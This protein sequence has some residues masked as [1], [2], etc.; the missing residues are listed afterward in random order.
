MGYAHEVRRSEG[1]EGNTPVKA[2]E[3][4]TIYRHQGY[5][6]ETRSSL[7]RNVEILLCAYQILTT[8]FCP[9]KSSPST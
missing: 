8:I 5:K 6:D 4:V 1:A 2:S 3:I 9:F 7:E